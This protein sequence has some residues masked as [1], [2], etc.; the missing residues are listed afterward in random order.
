MTCRGREGDLARYVAG[1]LDE[2]ACKE[3]RAHLAGCPRCRASEQ[4]L[5]RNASALKALGDVALPAEWQERVHIQVTRRL[6]S[7]PRPGRPLR[8]GSRARAAAFAALAACLVLA[9]VA[10]VAWL[11]RREPPSRGQAE[12]HTPPRLARSLPAPGV[13]A[14]PPRARPGTLPSAPAPRPMAERPAPRL[15]AL[16]QNHPPDR[17]PE[18]KKEPLVIR[19]QTDDP[20]VVVYWQFNN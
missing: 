6:L 12:R 17:G 16:V 9:L 13:A 18:R 14:E 8:G 3:I 5:R 2:A 15:L 4:A 10:G 20:T 11:V 7:P 19:L 1:E